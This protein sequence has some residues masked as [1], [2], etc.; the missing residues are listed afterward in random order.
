MEFKYSY[1]VQDVLLNW[2]VKAEQEKA[3]F[4]EF[5]FERYN[6]SNRLYTGLWERFKDDL[7]QNFRSRGPGYWSKLDYIIE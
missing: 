7:A 1:D 5:L 2:N 4:I 3:D 6:P